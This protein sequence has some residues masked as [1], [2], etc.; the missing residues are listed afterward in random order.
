MFDSA[1]SR[2]YHSSMNEISTQTLPACDAYALIQALLHAG[3]HVEMQLDA[4]LAP[5]GLS[6][7]KW[8]ALRHLMAADGQLQLGQLAAKLACVKSNATQLV[9]RL[10]AEGLVCRL[11]DPADRRRTRAEITDAGR[12]AFVQGQEVVVAFEQ[13]LLESFAPDEQFALHR[14]LTRLSAVNDER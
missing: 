7:A 11:P 6:A 5:T 12:Q 1:S 13:T 8:N 4:A 14:L 9:D 3:K 2:F 10:E